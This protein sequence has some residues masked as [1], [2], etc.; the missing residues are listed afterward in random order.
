MD[1][2]DKIITWAQGEGFIR[3]VVLTG[4]RARDEVIDFLADYDVTL[5]VTDANV[6]LENSAWI[7]A[8]DKVWIEIADKI[9]VQGQK[10]YHTRLV[11]FEGGIKVDF[12]FFTTDVLQNFEAQADLVSRFKRGYTVLLDEDS[13]TKTLA[14]SVPKGPVVALK[15]SKQEFETVVKEFFFEVYHVAKYLYRNELWL[16]KFRDWAVKEFLLRMIEWHEAAKHNWIYDTYYQGKHIREWASV[17]VWT[18]LEKC[19]ARFDASDSWQALMVTIELFRCVATQ[20]A[21]CLGYQYPAD[22]DKNIIIFV[23]NLRSNTQAKRD[24]TC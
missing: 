13:I 24:V 11:I 18:L 20:T 21:K 10:E 15:P 9:C 7:Y 12:A 14:T 16:V 5:F 4:S 1:M 8:L 22:I 23:Q 19:F 3:A 6:Y 17:E 2:L